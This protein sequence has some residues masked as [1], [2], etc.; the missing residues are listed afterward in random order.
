VKTQIMKLSYNVLRNLITVMFQNRNQVQNTNLASFG[1]K[2]T[3]TRQLNRYIQVHKS[4]VRLP[5]F[6]CIIGNL[7][8]SCATSGRKRR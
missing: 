1:V 8:N 5:S 2:P 3:K 4:A 6:C 7:R